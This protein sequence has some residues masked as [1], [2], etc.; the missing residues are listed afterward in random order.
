M[1]EAGTYAMALDGDKRPVDALA[2]NAGHALWT[3]H[4]VAGAGG[5]RRAR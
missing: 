4:R 3:R 5:A 1:D 2:S